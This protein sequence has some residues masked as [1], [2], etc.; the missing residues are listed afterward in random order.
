MK[1]VEKERVEDDILKK[2]ECRNGSTF[3]LSL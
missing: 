2:E 1:I 3:F